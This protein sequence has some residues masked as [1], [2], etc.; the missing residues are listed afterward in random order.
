MR[1]RYK[2]AVIWFVGWMITWPAWLADFQGRHPTTDCRREMAEGMG[3]A[4][5]PTDWLIAPF[6]TGFWEYGMKFS[7]PVTTP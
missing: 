5:L 1:L 6:V 2:I 7:C 4:L 3:W